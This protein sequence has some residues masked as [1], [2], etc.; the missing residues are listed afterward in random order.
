MIGDLCL[1]I[2]RHNYVS[3]INNALN[4]ETFIIFNIKAKH[5]D[6]EYVKNLKINKD[7]QNSR[8]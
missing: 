4:F 5:T 8:S 1:Q 2:W 7:V 3:K 6:Q